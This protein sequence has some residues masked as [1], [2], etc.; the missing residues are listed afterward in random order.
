MSV[1]SY[2]E[3]YN[4]HFSFYKDTIKEEFVGDV[5]M[6]KKNFCVINVLK[7]NLKRERKLFYNSTL[8]RVVK[9]KSKN[10]IKFITKIRF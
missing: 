4:D 5:M 10:C 6:I 2:I 7:L 9:K 3:M 8:V 1:I